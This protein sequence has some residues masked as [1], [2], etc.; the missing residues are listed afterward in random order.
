[1]TLRLIVVFLLSGFVPSA[2]AY[3]AAITNPKIQLFQ[4][5]GTTFVLHDPL[6]YRINRT[7]E[8]I[9][10]PRGFV[11]DFASVPWFAQSFVS[12]L[13]RHS[14]PAI[15]HDYLYWQR[16]CSRKE[17][18]LIL[19]DAMGEYHTSWLQKQAV[20]WTVRLFGG[21][22]W[23]DNRKD[24]KKGLIKILPGG[25]ADLPENTDWHDYRQMLLERGVKEEVHRATRDEGEQPAYCKLERHNG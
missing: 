21:W 2:W 6:V 16:K 15:A 11:T 12:I 3:D 10:I 13:G 18:D 22:A 7:Y 9:F 24:R 14:V 5:D 4:G 23:A 19:Y 17:A 20:Y 25:W 1:M 8:A